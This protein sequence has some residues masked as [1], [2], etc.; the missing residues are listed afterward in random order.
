LYEKK[1]SIEKPKPTRFSFSIVFSCFKKGDGCGVV[2]DG[3]CRVKKRG[4]DTR[5]QFEGYTVLM[6]TISRNQPS[7]EQPF[8][9]K[10]APFDGRSESSRP[11]KPELLPPTTLFFMLPSFTL[12]P[13]VSLFTLVTLGLSPHKIITK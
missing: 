8:T 9:H 7:S 4:V 3:S 2:C 6:T 5:T 11:A 1:N 13:K 12:T 10:R